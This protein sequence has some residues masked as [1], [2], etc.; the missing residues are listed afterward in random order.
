MKGEENCDFDYRR[1]YFWPSDTD[2]GDSK[3]FKVMT[4]TYPRVTP[5]GSLISLLAADWNHKL[6]TFTM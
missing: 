3:T 1:T 4:S 5:L 6:W 2:D